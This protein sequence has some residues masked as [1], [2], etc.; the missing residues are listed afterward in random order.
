M[1][2]GMAVE[3]TRESRR[4]LVLGL[5]LIAVVAT[6]LVLLYERWAAERGVEPAP[7]PTPVPTPAPAVAPSPAEPAAP[8]PLLGRAN[9]IAVASA[10]ASA[11]AAG[12]PDARPD[13]VGRRFRVTSAFGCAGPS[14]LEDNQAAPP[15]YWSLDRKRGRIRITVTPQDWTEAPFAA[16]LTGGA[17]VEAVQGF[18]VP[19]PWFLSEDCPAQARA[20]A[21][22][23]PDAETLGLAEI[24]P[25]G[26][27]R[28]GRRE[29]RP[30]QTTIEA[31]PGDQP[32]APQGYRLVLEGRIS[33]FEDGTAVRCSGSGSDRRPTCFLATDVEQVSIR[34]PAAGPAAPPLAEWRD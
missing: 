21:P 33:G 20:P 7:E 24:F 28:V 15:A 9:L 10:A 4:K 2:G 12:Q 16:A 27:S 14:E 23:P 26:S 8:P 25:P 17:E 30:Y 19:R 22:Q 34:D 29:G 3:P 6:A 32:A 5:L 13:L 1:S 31:Q 11:H 18:W